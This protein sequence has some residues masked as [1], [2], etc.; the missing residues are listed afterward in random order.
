MSI[1]GITSYSQ[2]VDMKSIFDTEVLGAV[3]E[4]NSDNGN[5]LGD[6]LSISSPGDLLSKLSQLQESDPEAFKTL[7]TEIADKLETAASETDDTNEAAVLSDLASKFETAGETGDLSELQPPPPPDQSEGTDAGKIAQYLM[8]SSSTSEET[9][10]VDI[11]N[12]LD[13]DS[14]ST[15]SNLFGTTSSNDTISAIKELLTK[16]IEQMLANKTGDGTG[17]S[18]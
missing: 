12:E 15:G 16:A 4:A 10:L 11:L 6:S 8:N 7:M 13:S 2:A 1:T 9:T 3:S 17:S 14:D 5:V 18:S